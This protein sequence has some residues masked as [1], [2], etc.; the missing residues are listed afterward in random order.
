MVQTMLKKRIKINNCMQ[1]MYIEM[2]NKNKLFEELAIANVENK[3]KSPLKM[4]KKN[5]K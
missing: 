3:L 1:F 4:Q 5:I 2:D